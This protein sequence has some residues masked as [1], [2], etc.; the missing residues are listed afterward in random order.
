MNTIQSLGG[1]IAVESKPGRGTS[2]V[3]TLPTQ[4]GKDA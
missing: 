1:E 4:E 2:F 3:I